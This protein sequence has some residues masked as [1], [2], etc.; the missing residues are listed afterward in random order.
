MKIIETSVRRPVTIAMLILAIV[1]VGI[2]SLSRLSI[3]LYPKMDL[4]YAVVVAQYSG[5]GPGEVESTVTEP[6]ED[7]LSTVEH[8][9]NVMST[10][11]AGQSIVIIE[12]NYG[13]DINFA[14]LQMREKVDLIKGM[15]P[16]DVDN[17]MVMKADPSMM[18]VIQLGLSG[19]KDL[20]ELKDIGENV[21]KP[22]LER[23][24]G[25]ASVA[26]TGGYTRE[27]QILTDPVKMDAYGVG[28]DQIT[29][30]L[31]AENMN[32][33]SGKV[34]E[35]N[36]ELFVRT[37]GQFK[38]LDDIKHLRIGLAGGKSIT[39]ADIAQVKDGFAEQT[40]ISRM[41]GVPSVSISVQKQSEANTVQVSDLVQKEMVSLTQEIPGNI[42]A[43]T[44]F[45]QATFIRQ[46]INTLSSHAIEGGLL[47]VIIVYLFLRS[48][49][50]TIIIGL[51]LP[52][53][54]IGIFSLLYAGGMTLNMMSLGGLA[55]GLGH[56][57]D[58]SIVVL[59]SIYRYRQN[60]YSMKEAAVQGASEVG[61]PVVASTLT[62][63]VVFLPMVFVE[64]L[65]S[66]LFR[67][68]AL[69]VVSSQGVALLVA[70]T[71][72]PML[73]SKFLVV[74]EHQ[75]PL[76]DSATTK[77]TK[78]GPFKKVEA[79]YGKLLAWSLKHRK[80]VV[81][82]VGAIMVASLALIPFI[83][84][85]FLPKSDTG[86]LSITM[87]LDKGTVLGE[88][89]RMTA[90]M[91][92]ELAEI[93]EI[94]TVFVSVG[95]ADMMG[96][97]ASE[98]ARLQVQLVSLDERQRSTDQ[99]ADAIRERVKDI[100]GAEIS[101]TVSDGMSMGAMSGAPISITLKGD[102][103][104]V[105]KEMAEEIRQLVSSVPGTREV[106]SSMTIGRPELQ[107]EVN[108]DRAV[109][110]GISV[111]Q[112]ASA[113]R[114]A[115]DGNVATQYRSGGEEYNIRV[116]LPEEYRQNIQDLH[117]V[118]IVTPTGIRVPLANLIT[119]KTD[120]GPT[121]IDRENRSRVATIT[122][123]ISG[124]DLGSITQEI[125]EK[126]HD[127]TL[128]QGYSTEIGGENAEMVE[129]FSSLFLA[130]I[131]GMILTYM[132]MAA[133]FESLMY[134]F[135]IMFTVPTMLVGAIIGLFLTGRSISV[136]VFI[137][138][139]MLVGIVVNN[140]IVLVDYINVLRRRGLEMTEA[141]KKAGPIRLRPVMMT[142]LTTAIAM[143]PLA[144]G[145][146]EGA[147]YQAPMATVV[148]GGLTTSTIFTLVFVPVMYS[149]IDDASNWI[150]R[151]LGRKTQKQQIG[152]GE[153]V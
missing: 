3:D 152:E 19:G 36:K 26:V 150:K 86:E 109:G 126:L 25:V 75:D 122:S 108:R 113:V 77:K 148:V 127:F 15:L 57:I 110:Y 29:Q 50:S 141:I 2:V 31:R 116:I 114:T 151:K 32:V 9:K 4:P 71:L 68:L 69:T 115:F 94:E 67:E 10:S 46:S 73:C 147:E 59:E 16:D 48:I 128:P 47:A 13:T 125:E 33:A 37:M 137:G 107:I 51:S 34:T 140:G 11:S 111:A 70:V 133:Q 52:I 117:N 121:Q 56:L 21:I 78:T 22:R 58:C 12:F 143:V 88:T 1:L 85:E 97:S 54:I 80:T 120:L 64:G 142:A 84:T 124:R 91:E 27:I 8:V 38:T 90:A 82:S 24:S 28:L 131:L 103:L 92:A 20:K 43:V 62:V 49:R 35:G 100:P 93:P 53:S 5:A 44:V 135:V 119:T 81:I 138:M 83:G 134:P 17:P 118:K 55:L 6:L 63:A 87:E 79:G 42:Q 149:L 123:Q 153:V 104:D 95:G 30:A 40:Q 145:I 106:E 105:L 39:L 146:G 101:V 144:L 89:D 130:L 61:M 14:T 96:T 74:R 129:S 7:V 76:L 60:G 65:S 66:M 23:L 41:N 136:V 102:D 99:V 132:V 72:V 112:V 18:P 45:D 98:V 139:I